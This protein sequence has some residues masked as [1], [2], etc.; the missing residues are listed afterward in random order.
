MAAGLGSKMSKVRSTLPSAFLVNLLR[1]Y[2]FGFCYVL[3]R[4][5]TVLM[6]RFHGG[7]NMGRGGVGCS[8]IL[9]YNSRCVIRISAGRAAREARERNGYFT[10]T[11]VGAVPAHPTA[12][13]GA[14]YLL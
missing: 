13:R 10:P 1:N 4:P 9:I 7:T 6:K 2:C 14:N 8:Q 3:G 12:K 5:K 11:V